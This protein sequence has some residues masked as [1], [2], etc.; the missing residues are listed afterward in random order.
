MTA[1]SLDSWEWAELGRLLGFPATRRA[2][3]LNPIEIERALGL[4]EWRE[5]S[6]SQALE[7]AVLLAPVWPE[8]PEYVAVS[9]V[10]DIWPS[11]PSRGPL[12]PAA[13]AQLSNG[14]VYL[15]TQD[16]T[17]ALRWNRSSSG[18]RSMG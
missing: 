15:T 4:L 14:V 5:D 6:R 17:Y 7:I 10:D 3:S 18:W 12:A 2:R 11:D 1:H 13:T 9:A 16:T 8:A